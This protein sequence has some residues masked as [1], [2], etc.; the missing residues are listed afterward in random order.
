MQL[1]KLKVEERNVRTAISAVVMSLVFFVLMP[2]QPVA[3]QKKKDKGD[4][5]PVD[6][7][8]KIG[9][10]PNGLTYYIR[11][12]D[13]PKNRAELYLVN[14]VGSILE[15]DD[16]LGLAHFS[17]HMAFN[18]TRD[19]PK[20]E[21]I[22]Y[23]Q[24]AG[25][26]FGADLN[27]YT[28]TDQT[29]YVLPIPTDSVALFHKGFDIL[30][31]WAAYV[32]FDS[33]EID[34][35]RGIVLEEERQ[36]GKNA[37]DRMSKQF[38]PVLLHDSRYAE[39]MP[40]GKEEVL[41]NFKHD[42]IKRFYKDWYRPNLQAIVAVG[43]FDVLEVEQLIKDR[44]SKLKNPARERKRLTYPV[45]GNKEPL[46]KVVTDPEYSG[47]SVS[48]GFMFP[49]TDVIRTV[50]DYKQSVIRQVIAATINNRLNEL[51]QM[52]EL[53][54]AYATAS[55]YP[56]PGDM[57]QFALSVSA[58]A[59]DSLEK[60]FQVS[61][62][63]VMRMSQ[64]GISPTELERIKKQ[65]LVMIENQ[66]K[67]RDKTSSKQYAQEYATHFLRGSAIPGIGYFWKNGQRIL[68]S[69]TV[70]DVNHVAAGIVTKENRIITL[71][72][73]E[74]DKSVL[75]DEKKLVSWLNRAILEKVIPYH[76][77]ESIGPL[78][79]N[80]PAPGT[81]VAEEKIASLGATKLVLSNGMQVILK[82]T[83]FKND[84]I[85][86]SG[87]SFGGLS[88]IQDERYR[89]EQN[90][91][92][93][94]NASGKG[95]HDAMSLKRTLS[96]KGIS[97][98][99]FIGDYTEGISGYSIPGDLEIALQYTY[100]LFT[101]PRIDNA[102]FGSTVEDMRFSVKQRQLE[103][104]IVFQDTLTALRTSRH[105]LSRP[106]T[107][108]E[109]DEINRE[110]ALT[111]YKSRFSDADDFTFV[112]VGNFSVDS[113]KPLICTYL[114]SLPSVPTKEQYR[115]LGIRGLPGKITKNVYRGLEDKASV[116]LYYH[117]D[118][119][120]GA[121]EAV[122]LKAL[123]SI[124]KIRMLQRLREKESGVYSPNVANSQS[125][126]PTPT[127]AVG[128]RFSCA[129]ANVDKLIEAARDEI[130]QIKKSGISEDELTKFVAEDRRQN[131][132]TVRENNHW[133]Q[134]TQSVALGTYPVDYDKQYEEAIKTLTTQDVKEAAIRFLNE[135]NFMRVVRL[136]EK[137]ETL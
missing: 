123:T 72:A 106:I 25:V 83:N 26:R 115:D 27:A 74:K 100:L 11:R 24:R 111:F 129:T 117:G 98:N 71:S 66:Y 92:S 135:E 122:Q 113:I 47:T 132:L 21:L 53:S 107:L 55:Y 112:F 46:A 36:R 45:F 120:R 80:I 9:K 75:P 44:F 15:D 10:L 41:R 54:F 40:I 119:K 67:E 39:R 137:K 130:N 68:S 121:D 116:S 51:K 18:G 50:Q 57:M 58:H 134:Y 32:S 114:A 136:P 37:S 110:E 127:Y 52:G 104:E 128:V 91:S 84:E 96:D 103:P 59:P 124:L 29:V 76:D 77:K 49:G 4:L 101:A 64:F 109:I 60:A 86:F 3:A 65:Y 93:L 118:S 95:D 108:P 90:A 126:I 43:D 125:I 69:I 62:R 56:M 28:G 88:L 89:S 73:N 22:N 42:A 5:L 63:E 2:A 97:V 131:E 87:I 33:E 133:L 1:Q 19:F 8:V 79:K 82:P 17:E 30:V 31:N 48:V 78:V 12:N 61:L 94:V 23:L 6:S 20:N 99:S 38:L 16:Q 105:R 7:Q 35:E 85:L 70:A 81:I 102:I 34:K 14:N 13:E